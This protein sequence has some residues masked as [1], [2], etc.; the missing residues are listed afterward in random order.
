MS[1][2][3]GRVSPGAPSACASNEVYAA[4]RLPSGGLELGARPAEVP[5]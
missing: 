1:P 5:V 3:P 2:E 4:P